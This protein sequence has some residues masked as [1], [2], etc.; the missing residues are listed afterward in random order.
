MLSEHRHLVVYD[1]NLSNKHRDSI[2]LL[3]PDFCKLDAFYIWASVCFRLP[4]HYKLFNRQCSC[5]LLDVEER[6]SSIWPRQVCQVPALLQGI[7]TF[8]RR[9]CFWTITLTTYWFRASSGN[10]AWYAMTWVLAILVAGLRVQLRKQKQVNNFCRILGIDSLP[11]LDHCGGSIEA[12]LKEIAKRTGSNPG[13]T[14]WITIHPHTLA[15]LVT[16]SCYSCSP[17]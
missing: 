15:R 14:R 5:L 4:K 3:T 12:E 8:E 16:Q 2:T 13:S 10:P 1:I 11:K 9:W 7:S 17:K 6:K